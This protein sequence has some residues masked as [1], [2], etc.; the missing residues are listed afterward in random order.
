MRVWIGSVTMASLALWLL[1]GAAVILA[2]DQ[3]FSIGDNQTSFLVEENSPTAAPSNEPP[4]G[5]P[6]VNPAKI[7]DLLK[8][9]VDQLLKVRVGSTVQGTNLNAPSNLVTPDRINFSDVSTTGGLVQKAPGVSIRRTSAINLDPRVRGYHSG[10]LNATANGMNEVKTRLDIDS[11]LSQIDPGIVED[12]TVID[13]PY[14]SLYGP[15]FAFLV[16]D[17]LPAPRYLHGP[18]FHSDTWF[19]YGTNGQTLYARENMFGGGKDWGVRVSYGLRD[20]N[21]YTIGGRDAYRIPSSY[22][23]WDGQYAVS[24][25]VSPIARVEFDYL[26]CDMNDVELPGVVYDL[27]NSTNNQFN[28]RYIVQEDPNGPKQ[29]ELQTWFQQTGFRGDALRPSKQ[30]TL[31]YQFFTQPASVFDFFPVN[32]IGQGRSD[33]LGARLL[34]TYG[35]RDWVQCT[36]GVDWR[37]FGQVYREINVDAEDTIVYDGNVFGIPRS[38]LDDYGV[39]ADVFLPYSDQVSFNIGGRVDYCRAWLDRNDPVVTEIS[40]PEAWYYTPGFNQPSNVLGMAYIT[41]KIKLTEDRTFNAGIAYAMR[42]PDLAELYSDDPYVPIARLGNSYVSGNSTLSPEHDLQFDL[43]I[44]VKKK[45]ISYAVR[46]FYALTWNYIMPV[47][48][49]ID[50]SPPG[51]IQAPKVLGRDFQAFPPEFRMDLVTGNVNA[52]TNQAGYQY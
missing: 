37:R 13:G 22:K 51:S 11:V 40:D 41:N 16:V 43:G 1:C 30:E 21:N 29:L 15:G 47:P 8:L 2:A 9:E 46:G 24:V 18:E 35:D 14:S 45:Q 34:R 26:R 12:I 50:P 36:V 20:G 25:D 10:Q 5:A 44:S 31:Y 28:L 33:C 3:P 48:A 32:T 4:S 42:M 6:P 39:L 19:Q 52:D 7:D 38:L 23:K 17:L 27:N 49:Y